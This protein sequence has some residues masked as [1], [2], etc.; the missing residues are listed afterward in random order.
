MYD[1]IVIG[2]GPGGANTARRLTARGHS[3]LILE[4]RAEA[5]VKLCTGIVSAE[6]A[7][8]FEIPSDLIW[9]EGHSMS[10]HPPMGDV[11]KVLRGEA[12]AFVI[13]RAAFVQS[14]VN[15]G[16][17]HGAILKLNSRVVDVTRTTDCVRVVVRSG[18][19]A[20]VFTARSIIVA[21]GFGAHLAEMVQM[22]P[23]AASAFGAQV[24]IRAIDFTETKVFARK[25]T[26][27]SEHGPVV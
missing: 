2:A 10:V 15:E 7:R 24:Q 12:Q 6:C 20:E 4:A 18:I 26:V 11:V 8:R 14:I 1:V 23:P 21:T 19:G 22:Q 3:V 27:C 17:Q 16:V 5:G 25:N 9:H 13:D